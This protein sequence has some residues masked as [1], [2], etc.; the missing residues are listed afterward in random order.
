MK[1]SLKQKWEIGS[2]QHARGDGWGA[3]RTSKRYTV[4][5]TTRQGVESLKVLIT[6]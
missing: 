5:R 1:K 3:G 4:E 6:A 2:V